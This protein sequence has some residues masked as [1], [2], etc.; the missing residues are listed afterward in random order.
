MKILFADILAIGRMTLVRARPHAQS[1][2]STCGRARASQRSHK[3][4]TAG[5]ACHPHSSA[6]DRT[7]TEPDCKEASSAPTSSNC[8]TNGGN[9]TALPAQTSPGR[10]DQPQRRTTPQTSTHTSFRSQG[11]ARIRHQPYIPRLHPRP[12]GRALHGALDRDHALGALAS[13]GTR[14]DSKAHRQRS[15]PGSP[16]TSSLDLTACSINQGPDRAPSPTDSLTASEGASEGAPDTLQP[17]QVRH[18]L[19]TARLPPQAWVRF[20]RPTDRQTCP[21][22]ST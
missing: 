8:K 2:G 4:R 7:A 13:A 9:A 21:A 6:K 11:V 12:L 1:G 20:S 14:L 17:M 16:A 19:M 15:I 18:Q 5:T 22:R 10:T 3:L